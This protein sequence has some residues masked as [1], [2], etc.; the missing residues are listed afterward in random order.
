MGDPNSPHF[1][2]DS[3]LVDR[4]I[5]S[6]EDEDELK[7]S[8]AIALKDVQSSDDDE[9]DPAVAYLARTIQARQETETKPDN[10]LEPRP[11]TTKEAGPRMPLEQSQTVAK[12][13][14]EQDLA[15]LDLSLTSQRSTSE[16]TEYNTPLTS[17]SI[18][19]SDTGKR[20]SAP[21]LGFLS[22]KRGSSSSQGGIVDPKSSERAHAWM[23]NYLEKRMSRDKDKDVDGRKRPETAGARFSSSRPTTNRTT[24]NNNAHNEDS[25]GSLSQTLMDLNKRLPALPG[26][27]LEPEQ[28]RKP[29]ISSMI[30]GLKWTKKAESS[31]PAFEQEILVAPEAQAALQDMC[32]KA[33]KALVEMSDSNNFA[34]EPIAVRSLSITEQSRKVASGGVEGNA[35]EPLFWTIPPRSASL[36][37]PTAVLNT[38]SMSPTPAKRRFFSKR[39]TGRFDWKRQK[40]PDA[41][42]IAPMLQVA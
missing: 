21:R 34:S 18:V 11:E 23:M 5:L 2:P 29:H 20:G 30:K 7:R 10:I 14:V 12:P 17:T 25:H 22:A 41:V 26:G 32:H 4:Q 8:C 35:H 38:I 1:I 6:I 3:P 27:P 15:G 42:G 40:I 24:S 19:L 31:P 9:V 28:T 37:T 13:P 33:G 36:S 16:P 39:F